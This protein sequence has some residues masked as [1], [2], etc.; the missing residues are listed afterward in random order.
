ME[1]EDPAEAESP[2]RAGSPLRAL[3]YAFARGAWTLVLTLG[4]ITAFVFL[5]AWMLEKSGSIQGWVE[6]R[7][8]RH[9]EALDRPL[10]LRAVEMRW[11]DREVVLRGVTLGEGGRDVAI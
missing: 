8:E 3:G 11:G 5:G 7:L 4:W 1:A 6:A 10:D 9:L 2:T